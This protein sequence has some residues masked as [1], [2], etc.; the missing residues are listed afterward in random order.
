MNAESENK[1]R[2]FD[3]LKAAAAAMKLPLRVLQAAKRA[4]CIAF[5]SNRVYETELVA[6]LS[7]NPE[8]VDIATNDP[9]DEL[10]REQIE[11]LR[12]ANGKARERLIEKAWVAERMQRTAAELNTFR[13]KSEAEHPTLFAAA[14]GDVAECR[15]VVKGIWDEIF[16]DLASLGKHFEEQQP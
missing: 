8:A 7:A 2:T 5:R 12:I 16:R 1:A 9:R 15:T 3:S 13:A 14:A 6:W 11:K 10:L 4:G